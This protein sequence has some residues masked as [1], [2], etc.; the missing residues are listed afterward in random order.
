MIFIGESSHWGQLAEKERL[1]FYDVNYLQGAWP[2]IRSRLQ[3]GEGMLFASAKNT[4]YLKELW[5]FTY[6]GAVSEHAALQP[7]PAGFREE[8]FFSGGAKYIYVRTPGL[9]DMHGV[10]EE[11]RADLF[12]LLVNRDRYGTELGACG[13]MIKNYDCSLTGGNYKGG[14]WY[15]FL[16]EDAVAAMSAE[17]WDRIVGTALSYTKEGCFISRLT[18]EYPLYRQGERVRIDY[19]IENTGAALKAATLTLEAYDSQKCRIAEI[20]I[21]ELALNPRDCTVGYAD[22]YPDVPGG[23]CSVKA[24]LR[25]HDRFVYGLRRENESVLADTAESDVLFRQGA[26]RQ[27]VIRVQGKD[28]I[29]DGEKDFFLGTHYYPSS[30][31]Y[32]LS[33]RQ[34]RLERAAS[35]IAAMKNAG[36]R[37]CRIWCDPVLDELSLRGMEALIELFAMSGIVVWIT[38]FTSWVHWLEVNT[39]KRRA[40][41]EAADMKDERLIGLIMHNIEAQRLYVAEMAERWRD[42]TNLVWD[43]TNEFSV[44]DPLPGQLDEDWIDSRY[45][46]LEPPFQS[47]DLFRQWAAQIKDELRIN[48]AEQPVVFGVSCWDTG[49][50]NYR[51]TQGADIVV[52]HTYYEIERAGYYVNYQNAN[53]AG[54]P[55]IVEEFGG[56]WPDQRIRAREYDLRY[57]YFLGAGDD[58]AISYEWG[59]SWLCDRMSGVPPYMKFNNDVPL[60]NQPDFVFGA[61]YSYGA[62]WPCGSVGVC[63]WVAS[64]EYGTN[65]SNTD[66][67]SPTNFITKRTAQLGKGLVSRPSDEETTFLVL[68]FET[69]GFVPWT[70]YPRKYERINACL[71]AL[72]ESGASFRIWQSDRLGALPASAKIVIYPNFNPIEADVS[73]GLKRAEQNGAALYLGGDLSFTDD[74]RLRKTTYTPAENSRLMIRKTDRGDLTLLF[75]LREGLRIYQIGSQSGSFTVEMGVDRHGLFLEKGGAVTMAEFIGE[76]KL[77][78]NTIAEADVKTVIRADVDFRT[79]DTLEVM[80]Y[81]AGIVRV[82]GFTSCSVRADDGRFLETFNIEDGVLKIAAESAA[83]VFVLSK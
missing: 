46:S 78:G 71:D 69:N 55:F 68:P 56:R 32:D 2:E 20:G 58:A 38:V 29:I 70:G 6:D 22:W 57:H 30:T 60:E 74:G 40:R 25:L 9:Y 8:R 51:C 54:K 13:M 33:Y 3:A 43:F 66:Y 35:T 79:T 41:F 81:G 67:E 53:S 50:E 77:D 10:Q 14:M 19:R 31:F 18:P 62:S 48:G 4:E 63:P 76:L 23:L 28:I 47:I 24:T 73:E 75:N 45:K 52:D 5:V 26:V 80:S 15:I 11:P 34:V 39:E 27:P 82:S 59:S 37:I 12:P 36:I 65:Y 72:W 49:S 42:R 61:R 1:S 83:Y 44:V 64:H 16:L 17:A 7:T 21:C